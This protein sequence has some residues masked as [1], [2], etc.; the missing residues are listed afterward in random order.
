MEEIKGSGD[1]DRIASAV[2]NMTGWAPTKFAG[3]IGDFTMFAPRF[4]QA[5]LETITKG[6][7]GF[8]PGAKIDQRMARNAL[9]KMIG[10]GVLLT[11]AANTAQGEETDFRLIVDGKRNSQFMRIKFGGQYY[12]LFG[13]WDSLLGMMVNIG[14]GKPLTAIRS[15][16]SGIVSSAWDIITGKDYNWEPVTDTPVD[17]AKWVFSQML[18]FSAGQMPEA[19]KQVAEGD[20]VGGVVQGASNL[21]GIKSFPIPESE[22]LKL[23]PQYLG[24]IGKRDNEALNDALKGID[25]KEKQT[26]IMAK[27]WTYDI[28]S[29]RRDIGNAI[30]NL[31]PEDMKDFPQIVS[32]WRTFKGQRDSYNLM[33]DEEQSDFLKVNPDF[34]NNQFF[35]GY[36][37]DWS[38]KDSLGS[39]DVATQVEALAKQYNVPLSAIPAFGKTDSGKE[40]LPT[41]ALWTDF[42]GYYSLDKQDGSADT[43]ART[44]F[45]KSHTAFEK[46]GEVNLGWKPLKSTTP[47]QWDR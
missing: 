42:F 6:A 34:V 25:S 22:A 13:T 37:T 29:L 17:F 11:V 21:V 8:R 10:A 4:F 39:Y 32:D 19:V 5:R 9:L 3:S 27:D 14:T 38:S 7:G 30:S 45:R 2:N 24:M 43:S 31:K 44:A 18:P 35:W 1:L 12:S 15:T 16:S 20:V 28:T 47:T 23:I 36:W 26:E 41:R 33:G 46:W 40:R